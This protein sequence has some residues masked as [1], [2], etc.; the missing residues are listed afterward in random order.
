MYTRSESEKT[1]TI[2]SPERRELERLLVSWINRTIM[3]VPIASAKK[4][5]DTRNGRTTMHTTVTFT[6]D[7]R[8]AICEPTL[9]VRRGL[10]ETFHPSGI[11]SIGRNVHTISLDTA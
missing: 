6:K 5:G 1:D 4:T 7:G 2:T 10:T 11:V 8:K 3:N 9:S